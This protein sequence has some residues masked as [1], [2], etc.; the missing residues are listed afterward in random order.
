[1]VRA[2]AVCRLRLVFTLLLFSS[3][4]VRRPGRAR[5]FLDRLEPALNR[6]TVFRAHPSLCRGDADLRSASD[7]IWLAPISRPVLADKRWKRSP[8]FCTAIASDASKRRWK[9]SVGK[10][11]SAWPQPPQLRR[12][13]SVDS[14][15]LT[16]R[17]SRLSHLARVGIHCLGIGEFRFPQNL[18]RHADLG[19]TSP[20]CCNSL[21]P[22]RNCCSAVSCRSWPSFTSGLFLSW[23]AR[24]MS[25]LDKSAPALANELRFRCPAAQTHATQFLVMLAVL[26]APLPEVIRPNA[27]QSA[28]NR[29]FHARL[30]RGSGFGTRVK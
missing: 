30:R 1:V 13:A 10:I 8:I 23:R 24:V 9:A 14:A 28:A 11:L 20:G 3:P 26:L 15:E 12:R 6:A 17:C 21:A 18:D 2:F 25:L 5:F 29:T 16:C 19:V 22:T 4:A 27:A 7:F